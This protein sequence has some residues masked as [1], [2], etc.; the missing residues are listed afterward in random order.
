MILEFENVLSPELCKEIIQRFEL[1]DRK[2]KGK[3]YGDCLVEDLK[4]S[5]DLPFSYYTDWNCIKNEIFKDMSGYITKFLDEV[6][7]KNIIPKD[8]LYSRMGC[9]ETPWVNIQRT[10]KD[11]FFGWHLDYNQKEHR[12]LGFIYY[13]NTLDEKDGGETEFY[14]GTKIRPKEGKLIMFPTDIV[15]FHRGCVV[16]TEKSKYIVTGFICKELMKD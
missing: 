15:H 14:N 3:C 11:G 10:D 9:I 13:L 7:K 5:I 12:I 8:I 16:K 4:V 1:D 2:D 6:N